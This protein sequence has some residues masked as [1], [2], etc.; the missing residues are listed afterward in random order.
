MGTA[1]I[2][3]TTYQTI[4]TPD[5]KEWIAE[6]LRYDALGSWHGATVDNAFG[7]LYTRAERVTIAG[8]IPNGW[9][10][11]SIADWVSLHESISGNTAVYN[12]AGGYKTAAA[13]GILKSTSSAHWN[14][15]NTGATNAI[16]FNAVGTGSAISPGTYI[17][18]KDYGYSWASDAGDNICFL[19]KDSADAVASVWGGLGSA[20]LSIRLVRDFPFHGFFDCDFSIA[21]EWGYEPEITPSLTWTRTA[22]G[23]W[24]CLDDGAAFDSYDTEITVKVSGAVHAAWESFI[25][26]NRGGEVTYFAP[27]G[28]RPFGPHID[29]T[30]GVQVVIGAD[31]KT[32]WRVGIT[33]DCYT[34]HI[35]MRYVGGYTPTLATIPAVVS[36]KYQ[37]PT[38]FYPTKVHKTEAGTAS[39]APRADETQTTQIVIDNLD[40]TAAAAM[41]NWCLYQR[42]ASF[43]YTPTSGSY[44]FGV[45]AG[46]GPF[47]ARLIGWT[48]QK[49]KPNRWDMTLDLA[50]DG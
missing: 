30:G 5:R 4:T 28:V 42:G 25:A 3:G 48:C 39:A 19:D 6:Y 21:P 44:P 38:W 18:K 2:L 41:V 34:L 17:Q 36:R 15:P 45:L 10:I 20:A 24:R 33:A 43:T 14:A 31:W 26:S 11:P 12:G 50:R 16:G 37:T 9:R 22:S 46:D 35:P 29:C 23:L 32:D 1:T 7:K 47:T 27:D 40:Q 13:G 49:P 8:L